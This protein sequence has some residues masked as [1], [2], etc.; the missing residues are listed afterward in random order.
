MAGIEHLVAKVIGFAPDNCKRCHGTGRASFS[1]FD[2]G[3]VIPCRCVAFFDIDRV[4]GEATLSEEM[5]EDAVEQ[6][7]K[8]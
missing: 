7:A 8:N 4:R 1:N 2:G 5:K 6:A 3:Q